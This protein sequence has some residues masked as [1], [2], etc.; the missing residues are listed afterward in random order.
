MNDYKKC[1]AYSL[2]LQECRKRLGSKAVPKCHEQ[3]EG[4][5]RTLEVA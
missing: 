2:C 5:L 1:Y 4:W 3:C